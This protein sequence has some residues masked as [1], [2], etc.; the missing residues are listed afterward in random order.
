MESIHRNDHHH[1]GRFTLWAKRAAG[2]TYGLLKDILFTTRH[3]RIKITGISFLA[4]LVLYHW[5]FAQIQ[6]AKHSETRIDFLPSIGYAVLSLLVP[7]LALLC[8]FSFLRSAARSSRTA[9][10]C[11][12]SRSPP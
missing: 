1:T 4:G 10:P 5:S 6:L 12:R 8:F 11:S 7:L 3:G 9:S 2:V